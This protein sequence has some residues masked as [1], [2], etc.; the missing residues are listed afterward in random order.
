[1]NANGTWPHDAFIN[2]FWARHMTAFWESMRRH[3]L[4]NRDWA[5]HTRWMPPD[6]LS[7]VNRVNRDKCR[8]E[9]WDY[10]WFLDPTHRAPQWTDLTPAYKQWWI[11]SMLPND[12]DISGVGHYLAWINYEEGPRQLQKPAKL[13]YWINW[14]NNR[15]S[16]R[17][18]MAFFDAVVPI[19]RAV[20]L[21]PGAKL[22]MINPYVV[23]F[24]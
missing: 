17:D 4:A 14:W 21:Q 13:E 12:T 15:L 2:G 11:W 16:Q 6:A 20:S 5:Q 9:N 8:I 18:K 22:S 23:A 24:N 7:N 3:V 19:E 10:Q 1:M